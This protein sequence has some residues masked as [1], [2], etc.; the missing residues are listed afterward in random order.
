MFN[1]FHCSILAVCPIHLSDMNRRVAL[2]V[3]LLLPGDKE[4]CNDRSLSDL[5]FSY[6]M[7]V[8]KIINIK[9][10]LTGV[11]VVTMIMVRAT[12]SG[13]FQIF[14]TLPAF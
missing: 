8:L 9:Y 13:F 6:N 4:V 14:K 7:S 1:K 12:K 10:C 2:L 11:L 5:T 3:H